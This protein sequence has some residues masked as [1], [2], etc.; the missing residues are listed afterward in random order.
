MTNPKHGRQHSRCRKEFKLLPGYVLLIAWVAF[1]AFV[2]LWIVA[3]SL[4]T[5]AD[6]MQGKV[7]QNLFTG[8]LHFENYA[9]A[10]SSNNVSVYFTN[11]LLYSVI[12]CVGTLLIAA[13]AAYVLSRFRFFG[14]Q[15]IRL[16]NVVAMSVPAVMIILPLFSLA[17]GLELTNNRIL[18]LVLV[19]C[20]RVPFS[21]IYLINFFQSLSRTYEEAASIDGCQAMRIFWKIMLP[22]VQPA[23]IT[24]TVFN[25]LSIWN[26]YFIA[27]IFISSDI[28]TGVGVGLMN[29]VNSMTYSGDYGG[30][31]AAVIIVFLP[32]F[33]LYLFLSDKIINGV[34]A[35]GVKG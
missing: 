20:L 25:F 10:W 23:L 35:G 12:G 27:M 4:A 16:S 7:W 31:F 30:L 8:T 32:T 24:V 26:E 21:T 9:N 1:T 6:I 28:K 19:I 13:P 2:L 3:A 5:T 11:S 33:I 17:S 29:I 22:L 14:N 18:Y 15:S 34:T